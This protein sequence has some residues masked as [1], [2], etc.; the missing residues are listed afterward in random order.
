MVSAKTTYLYLVVAAVAFMLI[1][2]MLSARTFLETARRDLTTTSTW[3]EA[4]QIHST[5]DQIT[6]DK[7]EEVTPFY[8]RI[9]ESS[10]SSRSLLL[11]DLFFNASQFAP[12]P[13]DESLESK[14]LHC[15]GTPSF[16]ATCLFANIYTRE[17]S[18]MPLAYTVKGSD[19][20]AQFK[21]L[22]PFHFYGTYEIANDVA[23]VE[24]DTLEDLNAAAWPAKTFTGLTALFDSLWPF[25]VGHGIFDGVWHVFVGLVE[26]GLKPRAPFTPFLWKCDANGK[27]FAAEHWGERIVRDLYQAMS[28]R[29]PCMHVNQDAWGRQPNQL[30]V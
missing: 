7:G 15:V 11:E 12:N 16:N 10:N 17:G 23:V 28:L 29:K 9:E 26:L 4:G 8:S 19:S 14:I 21:K 24:F 30:E 27:L 1:Y 18:K 5:T 6:F 2:E 22:P 13:D 3:N 25:N 20:W